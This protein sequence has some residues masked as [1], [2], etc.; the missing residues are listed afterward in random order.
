MGKSGQILNL[1]NT[2]FEEVLRVFA[3]IF[4]EFAADL[5]INKNRE[6]NQ[7]AAV[8]EESPKAEENRTTTAA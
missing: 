5:Q 7:T 2:L 3:A 4:R 6:V 1:C 8:A